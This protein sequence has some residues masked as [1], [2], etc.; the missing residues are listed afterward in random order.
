MI[1]PT[2]VV[3]LS[4]PSPQVVR[5]LETKTTSNGIQRARVLC[6]TDSV[7]GWTT[8]LSNAGT[9]FFEPIDR[10]VLLVQAEVAGAESVEDLLA[11]QPQPPSPQ[12]VAPKPELLTVK[13]AKN[14]FVKILELPVRG[15]GS[16][17]IAK[18]GEIG[19]DGEAEDATKQGYVILSDATHEKCTWGRFV[20][21]PSFSQLRAAAGAGA[22]TSAL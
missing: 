16:R 19:T 7:Q 22:E 17:Y 8:L 9:P 10:F 5:L 18:V 20:P 14:T 1:S 4:V 2:S 11:A 15:A 13:F 12:A 21:Y 3:R 6:A